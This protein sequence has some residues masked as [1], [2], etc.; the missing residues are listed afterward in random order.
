MDSVRFYRSVLTE[1][2]KRDMISLLSPD[3]YPLA[4][5]SNNGPGV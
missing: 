5:A 4:A 3:L 2:Y 1:R